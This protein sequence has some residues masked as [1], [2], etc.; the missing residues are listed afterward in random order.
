M[1][2]T[3]IALAVLL[4]G[5]GR[6]APAEPASRPRT[7]ADAAALQKQL[8]FSLAAHREWAAATRPLLDLRTEHP[9]DPEIH[10]LLG[11]VYR[12]QGLFEQAETSYKTAIQLAPKNAAAHAGLGILREVRGDAD[13]LA[14]EDF[15][16]AIRLKPDEATYHNNLAFALYVRGRYAEAESAIQKGLLQDPFSKRMRNNLGFIYAKMGQF[17]RAKR[18]FE[19]GGRED[20]VENNLGYIHEQANELD[21]ACAHYREAL[22][23]NPALKVAAE[24]AR[25]VCHNGESPAKREGEP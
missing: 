8:A 4:A 24:N 9:N 1:K 6:S 22:V 12:E 14:L 25:R 5:C 2:R 3:V 21:T 7:K 13:D 15:R 18:E 10:T 19:H 20:E 11:T 23:K 16:T 17:S